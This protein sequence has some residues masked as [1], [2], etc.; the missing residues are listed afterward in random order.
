MRSHL[1]PDTGL[2]GWPHGPSA[3]VQYETVAP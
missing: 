2:R 1:A 3:P